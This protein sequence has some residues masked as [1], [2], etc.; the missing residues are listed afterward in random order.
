[1]RFG[2]TIE[3]AE[4]R[5]LFDIDAVLINEDEQVEEEFNKLREMS[6]PSSA[7]SLIG[8][9]N[10]QVRLDDEEEARRAAEEE[11]KRLEE[12]L[13]DD[14]RQREMAKAYGGKPPVKKPKKKKRKRGS[15][16]GP[17]N[18]DDIKGAPTDRLF[19]GLMA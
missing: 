2:L 14:R 11:R 15:P 4:A 3:G 8:A 9:N 1:M 12:E 16:G 5:R 10:A 18:L 7:D 6:R 19:S 13:E 17:Q